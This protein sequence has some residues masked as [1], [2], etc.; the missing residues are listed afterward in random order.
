[1]TRL[2]RLN[3]A[4][5][6]AFEDWLRDGA[7]GQVP[8]E[9]LT[10]PQTSEPVDPAISIS[11]TTFRDRQVFG[12]YLVDVLKP[13]DQIPLS[14]D[15]RIW[16]WLALH[17]FDLLCPPFSTGR[18]LDKSYRY[19]LSS[20]YR[21]YYRHLVRS[22]WQLVRDHGDNA[23]LLLLPP[24]E[25]PYPL[26]RHGEI[27][28]QLGGRQSILRSQTLIA[29]ANLLYGSKLTGRPRKGVSGSGRGSVRRLA[30]VLRQF[31]LT[32]DVEV[33]GDG[34]LINILPVEFER[35]KESAV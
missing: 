34:K 1:M 24:Q 13:L 10:S 32:F 6:E 8:R 23:K 12:E 18:K 20:D 29:E 27:L 15:R 9:L 11:G 17:W 25:Q 22:P 33:M 3:D 14:S 2:R 35:W 7:E 19:V 31:D 5:I 30:I 28:E 4:G 21:H 26:R 16:T